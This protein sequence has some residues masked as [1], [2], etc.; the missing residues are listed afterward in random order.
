MT[1]RVFTPDALYTQFRTVGEISMS[2]VISASNCWLE[3]RKFLF[4]VYKRAL[5]SN[6]LQ[7]VHDLW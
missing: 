6:D 4:V 1:F 2:S 7:F 5:E 3:A